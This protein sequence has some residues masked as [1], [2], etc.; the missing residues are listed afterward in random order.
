[1]NSQDTSVDLNMCLFKKKGGGRRGEEKKGEER[2]E[3]RGEENKRKRFGVWFLFLC[4]LLCKP[5]FPALC[6]CCWCNTA[7]LSFAL[8]S[9][10][11]ATR[12][13]S[14]GLCSFPHLPKLTFLT[15]TSQALFKCDRKGS[16]GGGAGPAPAH[17][18][19]GCLPAHPRIPLAEGSDAPGPLPVVAQAEMGPVACA[20]RANPHSIRSA[21]TPAAPGSPLTVN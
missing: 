19:R 21:P 18:S 9:G 1:M 20:K 16:R 11:A 14:S 3:R 12:G 13:N 8:S 17:C 7:P 6:P 5:I 2:K 15:T 10:V 4:L